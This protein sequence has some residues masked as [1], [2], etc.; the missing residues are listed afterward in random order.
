MVEWRAPS[1]T[2][3]VVDDCAL[4]ALAGDERQLPAF[5]RCG[6]RSRR[7]RSTA[8][9]GI[10]LIAGLPTKLATNVLTGWAKTFLGRVV[11]LQE[12]AVH[13]RH[14][15]GHGHGLELVVRDVDD[16]R[17]EVVV[18]ALD[19]GA[20][21]HAQLGVEIG[22]RLVH[23]EDARV[24][25]QRPAERDALLL[26]ARQ[27]ARLALEQVRDVEHL[28]APPCTFLSISSLRQLP[29]LQR[30]GEVLEDRLLRIERV[31]LEHHRDV[32]V[33]GIEVVDHAVADEDVAARH[34]DQPGDEVERRRLAAA[35]RADQRHELA[36]LDGERDVVHGIDRPVVLDDVVEDDLGHRQ[37]TPAPWRERD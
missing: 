17:V 5:G 18:E 14:L 11:L 12:A 2:L 1:T 8:S 27:L 30:E 24:A 6:A 7:P 15:V 21:L 28:G 36:V 9:S 3:P 34:R 35:R 33:L 22:E 19:L 25:H 37:P 29:H 31:V 10:R 4:R 16:G 32:P 26:A 20:H 13:H 23:Q